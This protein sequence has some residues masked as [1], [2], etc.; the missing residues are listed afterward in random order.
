MQSDSGGLGWGFSNKLPGDDAIAPA[1][2]W[3]SFEWQGPRGLLG[4]LLALTLSPGIR[5]VETDKQLPGFGPA[6]AVKN[7]K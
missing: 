6:R 7:V 1:C 2:L 5:H 3:T 4:S